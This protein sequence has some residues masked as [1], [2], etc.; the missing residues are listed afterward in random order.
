MKNLNNKMPNPILAAAVA[1]FILW[2]LGIIFRVPES[3]LELTL[4]SYLPI[5]TIAF[6]I[7]IYHSSGDKTQRLLKKLSIVFLISVIA[8]VIFL[9]QQAR[10]STMTSADIA[11]VIISL[12]FLMI[13]ITLHIVLSILLGDLKIVK[14]QKWYK[15]RLKLIEPKGK[16]C[17]WIHS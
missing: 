14:S 17:H 16:T 4:L 13:A 3:K 11:S 6:L 2:P 1:L 8:I 5:G 10:F 15:I 12:A 7:V 9:Y